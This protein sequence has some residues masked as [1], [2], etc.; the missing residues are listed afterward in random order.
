M[1]VVLACPNLHEPPRERP[2]RARSADHDQRLYTVVKLSLGALPA[3][4]LSS[5]PRA[6]SSASRPFSFLSSSL[7]VARLISFFLPLHA[8]AHTH[9]R[10]RAWDLT[11]AGMTIATLEPWLVLRWDRY[12]DLTDQSSEAASVS[13]RTRHRRVRILIIMNDLF[14]VYLIRKC[15]A[16]SRNPL[17]LYNWFSDHDTSHKTRPKLDKIVGGC[18]ACLRRIISKYFARIRNL[19]YSSSNYRTIIFQ[20]TSRNKKKCFPFYI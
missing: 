5:P 9:S 8:L 19:K 14:V 1:R 12:L 4:F 18:F 13:Q 3:S 6:V 10:A 7:R 2:K 15:D 20:N 11:E 16:T 17:V